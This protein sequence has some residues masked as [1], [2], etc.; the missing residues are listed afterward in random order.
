MGDGG[1]PACETSTASAG[2]TRGL[3][4]GGEEADESMMVE[5]GAAARRKHQK[6]E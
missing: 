5:I 1:L 4:S 3:V 2:G 6:N